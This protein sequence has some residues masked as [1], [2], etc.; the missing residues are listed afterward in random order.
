MRSSSR[1]IP[2]ADSRLA[3]DEGLDPREYGG[4]AARSF[5]HDRTKVCLMAVPKPSSD[6]KSNRE[7]VMWEARGALLAA[8]ALVISTCASHAE[9]IYDPGASDTAIKIGNTMPYSGPN[10]AFA[11]VGRTQAAYFK[12]INDQGGINGRKIDYISY[13]DSY[14]PPKTVEQVR[15]LVESDEVLLLYSILGTPTNLAAIKYINSKKV[16]HL[17]IASGGTVFGDH[18]QFPGSM[19]FQP[20]SQGETSVYG[21]YLAENYPN[22]KIGVLYSADGL[23]RDNI[24][25]FKKGLGD[26]VGNVVV[27]QTYEV[28]DP[29]IDSQMVKIRTTGVDVFA[30]FTTPKF[31]AIAIRK[32]AEMGWKPVHILHGISLS[33][34][35][36]LKPAGIEN[37]KDLVTSNYVKELGDPSWD[38]DPGV[39]KFAAFID[40]YLPGENKHNSNVAYAYMSAQTMV[41]ILGQCGDDLTR[42]NVMRQAENLKDFELDLLLPGIKVNTSPT[43]HYPIRQTR[44]HRFDGTRWQG[45]GPVLELD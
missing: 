4:A 17:L 16:P 37:A 13:D 2:G 19:G 8:I 25:G 27:E 14:S 31:A 29:T 42:A 43:D 41:H 40:R 3:T 21:R 22:A 5:M 20:H 24:T 23:G 32:A 12:M 7:E 36:V 28:T 38:D 26:K 39:K 10:S 9:K 33:I 6:E 35:N 44:M 11:V 45:F 18:K 15:R 34:E 30:N 1:A